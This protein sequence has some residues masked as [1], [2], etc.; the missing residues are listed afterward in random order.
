MST[1]KINIPP[2]PVKKSLVQIALE[3][4]S[5]MDQINNPEGEI[6][7][8]LESLI[9]TSSDELS[10]KLDAYGYLMDRLENEQEQYKNKADAYYAKAARCRDTAEKIKENLKSVM[11]QM[12]AK[13]LSGEDYTFTI[14]ESKP[15]VVVIDENQ[16]PTSFFR[17]EIVS[18]LSKDAVREAIEKGELVTGATLEAS[19]TLRKGIK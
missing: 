8:E 2:K 19:Y 5:L 11:V 13:K 1:Y 9:G 3:F 10:N 16:I 14:S 17:Q 18:K 12:Q 4:E 6:T 15:K 7:V